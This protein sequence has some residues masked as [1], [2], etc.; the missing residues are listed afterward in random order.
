[1][2]EI[3]P[4]NYEYRRSHVDGFEVIYSSSWVTNLETR[5]HFLYYWEQADLVFKSV[6][7]D[8]RIVE[9]GC[10]THLLADLLSRRG[11]SVKTLDIDEEKNPTFVSDA[12]SFNY[13]VEPFDVLLAFEIFEHIPWDTFSK[14]IARVAESGIT[15]ILFSIPW[16]ERTVASFEGKVPKLQPFKVNLRLPKKAISTKAHFWELTKRNRD[17]DSNGKQFKSIEQVNEIFLRHGFTLTPVKRSGYI[18]FFAAQ[19]AR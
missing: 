3:D 8:N 2:A 18:Q 6:D 10:G 19:R 7:R 4:E 5:D 12:T 14:T 15:M 17:V 1:M 9:L 16:A 13:S 11:F